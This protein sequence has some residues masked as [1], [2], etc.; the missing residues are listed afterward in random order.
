MK[1]QFDHEF[2][3]SLFLFLDNEILYDGQGSGDKEGINFA[4]YEV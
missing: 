3:S 2:Q 4:Y 1:V